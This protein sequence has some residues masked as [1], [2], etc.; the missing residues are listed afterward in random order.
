M[1]W[2]KATSKM[3]VRIATPAISSHG[4]LFSEPLSKCRLLAKML[5]LADD[6]V[7][8]SPEQV[9]G[10]GRDVDAEL[11]VEVWLVNHLAFLARKKGLEQPIASSLLVQPYRATLP[12]DH[13][14]CLTGLSLFVQSDC[15]D[16]C[17]CWLL[18]FRFHAKGAASTRS[19]GLASGAELHRDRQ[20]EMPVGAVCGQT[21]LKGR[22]DALPGLLRLAE[23]ERGHPN[24]PPLQ[25]AP[26]I[27]E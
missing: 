4:P 12:G 26:E 1:P 13:K 24:R 7:L 16:K 20:I 9:I 19:A 2:T 17:D 5:D 21:A 25:G 18:S 27:L 3:I 22:P 8:A 6:N 11:L 14:A 10:S 15:F 23:H